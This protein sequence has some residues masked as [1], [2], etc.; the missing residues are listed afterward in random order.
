MPLSRVDMSA[1]AANATK[2]VT[3]KQTLGKTYPGYDSA[4]HPTVTLTI[5]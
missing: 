4:A 5:T 3:I 1:K 2:I